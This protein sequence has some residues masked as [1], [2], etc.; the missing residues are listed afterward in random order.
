MDC[1]HGVSFFRTWLLI[2]LDFNLL[3]SLHKYF[4][5]FYRSHVFFLRLLV[6]SSAL[7]VGFVIDAV[8]KACCLRFHY[9]TEYI[10]YPLSLLRSRSVFLMCET[11]STSLLIL[12]AYGIESL[13]C[14]TVET[15]GVK[16]EWMNEW[17]NER[18]KDRKRG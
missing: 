18:A 3:E 5:G 2:C 10:H 17:V 4:I 16:G 9:V 6:S 11:C 15:G 8:Q 1:V 7:F 14:D 13:E 12:N